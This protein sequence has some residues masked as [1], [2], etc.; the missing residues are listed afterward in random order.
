MELRH[1]SAMNRAMIRT[2][3]RVSEREGFPERLVEDW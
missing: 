3:N 1:I 2:F